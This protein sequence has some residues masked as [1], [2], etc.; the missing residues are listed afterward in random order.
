MCKN[1]LHF[2]QCKFLHDEEKIIKSIFK[3]TFKNITRYNDY[4]QIEYIKKMI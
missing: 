4:K 1:P 3:P 2:L